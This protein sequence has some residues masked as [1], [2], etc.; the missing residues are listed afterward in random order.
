MIP[1]L[2][3]ATPS[4]LETSIVKYQSSPE[5][6]SRALE[7][8]PLL[9]KLLSLFAAPVS[10]PAGTAEIAAEELNP[11]LVGYTAKI[12][13][14]L[15]ERR[16]IDIWRYFGFHEAHILGLLRHTQSPAVSEMLQ[17]LIETGF[18]DA[19]DE[20]IEA[21]KHDLI[22]LLVQNYLHW[23][24]VVSLVEAK[25]ELR[26]FLTEEIIGRIY[27]IISENEAAINMGLRL[28]KS[29]LVSGN[30]PLEKPRIPVEF[31]EPGKEEAKAELVKLDFSA[32]I[33]HGIER[34]PFFAKYLTKPAKVSARFQLRGGVTKNKHTIGSYIVGSSRMAIRTAK[35]G[36]R[37]QNIQ[38]FG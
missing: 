17:K 1:S 28:L 37:P 15:L 33:K 11:V 22:R 5:V 13:V 19:A 30:A 36:A 27:E 4:E 34:L 2:S 32:V 18:G 10:I 35:K 31:L 23:E 26:H 38:M 16:R 21:Q 3:S 29:I 24:C 25:I 14:S 20:K 12:F 9:E 7:K 8:F 6:S